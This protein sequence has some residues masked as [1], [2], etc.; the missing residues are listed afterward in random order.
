[1]SV[2]I[3]IGEVKL[4]AIAI[5]AS[6]FERTCLLAL[7]VETSETFTLTEMVNRLPGFLQEQGAKT[8]SISL[9]TGQASWH[10]GKLKDVNLVQV[11]DKKYTATPMGAFVYKNFIRDPF[12]YSLIPDIDPD[13]RR[14]APERK[15]ESAM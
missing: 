11:N 12:L 1:M 6:V 10:L 15:P 4:E 8:V 2:S 3:S 14:M 5:A 7:L 13:L 9:S